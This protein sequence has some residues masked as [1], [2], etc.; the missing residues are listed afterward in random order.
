VPAELPPG[1][2]ID[3]RAA[4]SAT[5]SRWPLRLFGLGLLGACCYGAWW[6]ATQ[7]LEVARPARVAPRVAASTTA[8]PPVSVPARPETPVATDVVAREA[9][10]T[11][12]PG[13]LRL[14]GV[15][16]DEPSNGAPGIDWV[17][18]GLGHVAA[19]LAQP[20]PVEPGVEPVGEATTGAS[21][22]A[23]E[24]GSSSASGQAPAGDGGEPAGT[25]GALEE[26]PGSAIPE[27]PRL[28][29]AGG[30]VTPSS[31]QKAVD[32]HLAKEVCEALDRNKFL[33]IDR[34][35]LANP[36]QARL[37]TGVAGIKPGAYWT[38]ANHR[39]VGLVVLL[40]GGKDRSVPSRKKAARPLCVATQ[41]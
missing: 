16:D 17:S 35:K 15:L 9:S 34:W 22:G 37:F 32:Q 31:A 29:S 24:E 33:G 8:V 26:G 5:G 39:G 1:L 6:Y 4:A 21:T 7:R 13:L 27:P 19:A 28:I 30:L 11:R 18:V 3:A 25:T 40:P 41:G 2:R 38:T 12:R 36:A 20:Q 10:T 23:A 14:W